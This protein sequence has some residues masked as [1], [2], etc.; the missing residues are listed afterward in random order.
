MTKEKAIKYPVKL[1]LQEIDLLKECVDATIAQSEK[2]GYVK[3][4]Y[5][6]ELQDL[7]VKLS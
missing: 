2:T 6:K 5:K 4:R 1:T 3:L 7:S